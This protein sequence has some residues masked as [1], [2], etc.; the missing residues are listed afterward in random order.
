MKL[1]EKIIPFSDLQN[2]AA[3]EWGQSEQPKLI[4]GI[5]S[6]ECDPVVINKFAKDNFQDFPYLISTSCRGFLNSNGEFD[7]ENIK[8]MAFFSQR[9]H[10][11]VGNA[12]INADPKKAAKESLQM[13]IRNSKRMGEPPTTIWLSSI[14]GDEELILEGIQAEVGKNVPIIGGSIADESI[15]GNWFQIT[16]QG[17]GRN[18]CA[19][20]TIY[21]DLQIATSFH[22]GYFKGSS[23]GIVT[24]AQKRQIIEIDHQPAFEVYSQWTGQNIKRISGSEQEILSLTSLHPLAREAGKIFNIPYFK[25]SHP[26]KVLANDAMSLFTD[27]ETGEEVFLLSGSVDD[28]IQKSGQSIELALRGN[29]I[30]SEDVLGGL[31]TFCAGCMLT[32]DE[33]MS[34]VQNIIQKVLPHTPPLLM[35]FTFGEQGPLWAGENAHGNLMYSVLLFS[36]NRDQIYE[37]SA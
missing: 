13:A 37:F 5:C 3:V 27:I 7:K 23:S 6:S 9:D 16:P 24:K 18:E 8:L 1:L 4:M 22:N 12:E 33:R 34:E 19:L 32:V 25:L 2:N 31:M 29:N 28:L 21:S 14:P 11:G 10:F 20:V 30:L 26:E 35:S 36:K 17:I 15:Q